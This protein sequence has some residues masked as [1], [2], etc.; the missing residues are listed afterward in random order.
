MPFG[1]SSWPSPGL[2]LTGRRSATAVPA[3][4]PAPKLRRPPSIS[5]PAPCSTDRT[6]S[7]CWTGVRKSAGTSPRMMASYLP[8]IRSESWIAPGLAD[9]PGVD[10]D[11]VGGVE[12]AGS[13][14]ASPRRT[15][16]A[17]MKRTLIPPPRT[18]TKVLTS[19]LLVNNSPS[20]GRTRSVTFVSPDFDGVH[21]RSRT[22]TVDSPSLA[23]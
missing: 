20:F 4:P 19:L 11:A 16:D 8:G 10:P 15:C 1:G 17:W 14:S 6:M 7:A 13:G 2:I 5:R 12:R 3:H 22:E 21:L 23:R 9:L 18:V